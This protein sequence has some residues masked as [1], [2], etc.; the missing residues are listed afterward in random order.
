MKSNPLKALTLIELLI[1]LVVVGTLAAMLVPAHDRIRESAAM[2]A[3]ANKI[4]EIGEASLIFAGDHGGRLPPR[5]GSG[6]EGLSGLGNT[7]GMLGSANT[8]TPSI[9]S[10]AAALARYGG[11]NDAT[12]WISS[13]DRH[14]AVHSRGQ[15]TV[16]TGPLSNQVLTPNFAASGVSYAYIAGRT[17]DQPAT[18]PVAFTRGLPTVGGDGR[19][20]AL[21]NH[22]VYGADGGYIVYLN[23]NVNFYRHTG[24]T[25]A[26]GIFTFRQGDPSAGQRTNAILRTANSSEA[27]YSNPAGPSGS[28]LGTVGYY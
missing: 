22:G 16:L 12:A 4:R 6:S 1:A 9:H 8:T 26:T 3:D 7:V 10:I 21:A 19:W 18:M 27:S 13:R 15:S 23:G 2:T 14:P 11:L 5:G 28:P 17:L 24:E 25:A 20:V